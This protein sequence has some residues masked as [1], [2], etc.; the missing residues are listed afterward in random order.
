LLSDQVVQGAGP[1]RA[2]GD[3]LFLSITPI[4]RYGWRHVAH[5]VRVSRSPL[6]PPSQP[7]AR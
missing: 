3:V 5:D 7:S 6:I 1:I 4:A 2:D